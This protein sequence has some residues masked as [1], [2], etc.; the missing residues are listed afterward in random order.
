MKKAKKKEVSLS[1][2]IQQG[3]VERSGNGFYRTPE[4]Q[5]VREIMMMRGMPIPDKH[6]RLY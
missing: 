1:E 2:K 5:K 6:I 3:Y 4:A